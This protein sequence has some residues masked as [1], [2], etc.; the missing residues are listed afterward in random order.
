[1]AV[2]SAIIV[3]VPIIVPIAMG[4]GVDPVHLGVIFLLNLEIGYMLPPLGLNIF[5]S[6]LK[7]RK[8]LPAVYHA[9][10]PFLLLLFIVLLLVTYAPGLSLFLSAG[11]AGP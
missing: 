6:S 10:M 9:V 11:K 5:L 2:F 8:T 7:F 1:M 4:Y 3:I